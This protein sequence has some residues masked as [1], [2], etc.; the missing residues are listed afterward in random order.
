M[1]CLP[2]TY[3]TNTNAMFFYIEEGN[4][5]KNNLDDKI[6][7]LEANNVVIACDASHPYWNGT[8]CMDCAITKYASDVS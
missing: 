6:Y 3:V 4:Y 2:V 8:D 5:T 1:K 7:E